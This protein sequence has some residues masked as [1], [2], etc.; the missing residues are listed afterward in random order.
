MIAQAELDHLVARIAVGYGPDV[1]GLFGSHA[2]GRA[3]ERSDLDVV[4][5]KSTPERPHKRAAHVRNL[6]PMMRKVDVV[7]LTPEEVVEARSQ[8]HSFHYTVVRQLKV[9]YVRPGF[10][11]EALGV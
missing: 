4:V 3:T 6:I 2:I 1:I 8:V 5:I 9:L 7:V 11:R 10:D